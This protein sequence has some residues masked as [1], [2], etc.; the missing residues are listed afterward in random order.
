MDVQ[1]ALSSAQDVMTVKRVYGEPF[2]R[3]GV[4]VIPAASIRG[5]GGGGSGEREG[6]AT[7]AGRGGGFGVSSRPVGAFIIRGRNVSWQPAIDVTRIVLLGQVVGITALLVLRGIVKP[8]ARARAR[9]ARA[10]G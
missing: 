8:R 3:D 7:E 4:I 6:E 5:G 1:D 10:Q 2:E 9:V